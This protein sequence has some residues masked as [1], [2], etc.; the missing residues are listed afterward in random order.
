MFYMVLDLFHMC[1]RQM[2]NKSVSTL[3]AGTRPYTSLMSLK[4]PSRMLKA[5]KHFSSK[6]NLQTTR[7]RTKPHSRPRESEGIRIPSKNPK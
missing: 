5:E 3:M 6:C 7:I 1:N 4:I 2:I